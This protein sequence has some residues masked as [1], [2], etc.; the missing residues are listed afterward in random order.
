[1]GHALPRPVA[2]AAG[3][4]V[5]EEDERHKIPCKYYAAGYCRSGSTCPYKHEWPESVGTP[6]SVGD[7]FEE[8]QVGAS[9]SSSSTRT[10]PRFTENLQRLQD[11]D[12]QLADI[13]GTG[14]LF[15][16]RKQSTIN[17]ERKR[18][19]AQLRVEREVLK[20][21]LA[22]L[23]ARSS[24]K[25][26][27]FTW[28]QPECKLLKAE[29]RD[30]GDQLRILD[31]ALQARDLAPEDDAPEEDVSKALNTL[32]AVLPDSTLWRTI[33]AFVERRSR[34][35]WTHYGYKVVV[36]KV[37]RIPS[38][39]TLKSMEQKALDLGRP[40][41]LFH[42]TSVENAA[43]IIKDGF[44]L[45]KKHSHGGMFGKGIY[46]AETPLK[47]VNYARKESLFSRTIGWFFGNPKSGGGLQMLLCDVHLGRSW[48]LRLGA[49]PRLTKYD[50]K[51][52]RLSK[53][54]GLGD[55]HS[56]YVPG[57]FFGAVR[58]TEYVIYEKWQAIPR[59]LI[60]FERN[61]DRHTF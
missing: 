59:Y 38:N 10:R 4:Q 2:E 11:L 26:G 44:Q 41:P 50:L 57:G 33:V 3:M 13:L 31:E 55:Y 61:C 8:E 51:A 36:K 46:F 23:D 24:V 37:W 42:G 15:A 22:D 30:V 28:L 48:C 21:Q 54:C 29:R 20:A 12:Q 45:P 47:S 56:V 27:W 32:E 9:A 1:M 49:R 19:L 7:A 34:N 53:L 25:I 16:R 18:F 5:L 17:A 43:R 35:S 40:T 52:G 6:T 58:V 60:E 14:G 39:A